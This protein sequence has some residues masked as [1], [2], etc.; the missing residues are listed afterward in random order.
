MSSIKND[1]LVIILLFL[2]GNVVSQNFNISN[3]RTFNYL[4]IQQLDTAISFHSGMKPFFK[5]EVDKVVNY[6]TLIK[7][8]QL[9]TGSKLVDGLVNKNAVEIAKG[10]FKVILNPII[11]IGLT[12]ER[13]NSQ[14]TTLLETSG[15][16]NLKSSF[17]KKWSGQL[18]FL[19]DN[20][21]YPSHIDSLVRTKNVSPG[22]G[23]SKNRQALYS[24]GN[25]TFTPNK[26]FAFQAGYGKHFIG[27]GYRSLFLSD[28]ANSYPYLKATANIWKIKYM[29]LYTNFQDVRFSNGNFNKYQ[30]KF[31]AIHY[32][33][34]NATKWLNIGFFESIVWQAGEKD[35][36]RAYD[37]SYFNPIIF[38]RPVEFSQG[39]SDNALMGASFKVR[40]KKKNIFYSQFLLDEFLLNELRSGNG[41]WANKFGIQLGL[42]AYDFLW[43]KNLQL[44]LEYNVVRPFT[45]SYS[46]ISSPGSTLQ[47][48][49]HFSLPLAHPLGA[50]FKEAVGG[51]SYRKK[52][53]VVEALATF[54]Q[55]G[56]DTANGN[57][58]QDIYQPYNNRDAEYGHFITQGL[59]TD[60]LNSTLQ[61]SYVLNPSSQ[62]ILQVGVSNR[63]YKN[64]QEN[65]SSNM[66]FVGLKT[67][68][69]NRYFDN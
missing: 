18:I 59:K 52:R 42:K 37:I 68:I 27:D 13:R 62:M 24:Q 31:S 44:Q 51:L 49:G 65:S 10:K 26:T 58:G 30:D 3:E 40:V 48:Y 60:I 1:I 9:K 38:L 63:I 39:S 25:L 2:G 19:V 64:M 16:L 20:S 69:I 21:A 45:Y 28:Y 41:W 12:L 53:W 43:V 33:S 56:L 17:S 67:A 61:F 35:F 47:N 32:L 66:I 8:Y 6:D 29:A 55:V 46:H 57:I 36:Y 4:F 5:N 11:N 50:N 14:N 23:Y 54:S 15:G 22:Y 7:S 34:Y